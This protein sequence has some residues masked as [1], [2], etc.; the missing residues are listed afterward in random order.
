MLPNFLYYLTLDHLTTGQGCLVTGLDVKHLD[1]ATFEADAALRPRL[2]FVQADLT[3]EA[4]VEAAF[5]AATSHHGKPP[6]ILVANAGITNE[7][8]HPPIW[9]ID[10][11]VWDNVSAVNLRGTFLSIKHFLRSA[12]R[13]QDQESREIENLAIVITGSECGKFGQEGHADYATGKAGLNYGLVRGVKNEIV[14]MNSKARINSVAP[15]WVDT[16][17]IGNRLDDPQEF[18]AETQAT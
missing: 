17:L 10:V 5:Q 8:A 1:T 7:A 4:D 6:Q 16:P 2:R 11:D 14:R 12:K 13:W 15:G 9:E 3:N 18:W